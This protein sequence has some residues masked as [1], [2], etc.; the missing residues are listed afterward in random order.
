MKK[1][2]ILTIA[3]LLPI[4]VSAGGWTKAVKIKQLLLVEESKLLILLSSFNDPDG[5]HKDEGHLPNT[6]HIIMDPSIN[7]AAYSMI[8]SAYMAQK[9]VTFYVRNGCTGIWSDTAYAN[10]GHIKTH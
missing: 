9:D 4:H 7:K 1:L 2:L 10:F 6:G 5:C 3:L 8:L